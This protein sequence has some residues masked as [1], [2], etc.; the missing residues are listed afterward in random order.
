MFY[1]R[2]GV[3]DSREERRAKRHDSSQ[4]TTQRYRKGNQ[5]PILIHGTFQFAG[6]QQLADHNGC[7]IAR[8]NERAEEQVGNRQID[9][10]SRYDFQPADGIALVQHRHSAGPEQFV[11]QQRQTENQH[12][13]EDLPGNLQ[14][15]VNADDE[16]IPVCVPVR[17]ND[18]N[19]HLNEARKNRCKRSA[20]Y[21]QLRCTEFAEDQD[22]VEHQVHKHRNQARLHR[23]NSL[24]C[25]PQR[26]GVHH[27]QHKRQQL[28][29][30]HIQILMRIAAGC[31]QIQSAFALMQKQPDK[32]VAEEHHCRAE[33][34]EDP[35]ADQ[36]FYAHGVPDADVVALA[37]ILRRQD[38]CARQTAKRAQIVDKNQ[39]V[40]NGNA[41]HGLGSNLADHDVVQQGNKLCN[42]ILDQNWHQDNRHPAV[43]VPTP[44]V[45][46]HD[47][48]FLSKRDRIKILSRYHLVCLGC[49]YRP[50]AAR[51]A[52]VRLHSSQETPRSSRPMCP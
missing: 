52:S 21:A 19:R 33:Y 1:L 47:F 45:S 10:H 49:V 34:N 5:F 6:A 14:A 51:N 27:G 24:A 2:N 44:D 25:F 29:Q 20:D 42:D 28:Q 9:I 39:L 48:R 46:A 36:Q 13:A 12:L 50:T 8:G 43:K 35:E 18:H 11:Y 31:F 22:V 4:H 3:V 17:P 30:H 23:E 32:P 7:G 37:V 40:D 26:A 15:A 38:A 41:A 16:G